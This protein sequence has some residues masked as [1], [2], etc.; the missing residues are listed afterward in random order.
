METYGHIPALYL[1]SFWIE[2]NNV[3]FIQFFT[4]LYLST[5]DYNDDITVTILM[6]DSEAMWPVT[7]DYHCDQVL[8]RS[9]HTYWYTQYS[10]AKRSGILKMTIEIA[11]IIPNI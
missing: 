11:I 4:I 6:C 2:G 3:K 10:A 7:S 9:L 1:S 5:G 8:T